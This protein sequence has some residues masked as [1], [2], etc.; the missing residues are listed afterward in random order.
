LAVANYESANGHLPP[1]FVRGPDGTPWHSWRVLILPYIEADDIFKQYRFDE[2]WDGPHNR[3]LADRMPRIFAFHNHWQPGQTTTNYL[4]VVGP[5]TA[6]PT[7]GKR[8][9]ADLMGRG[10]S[11]V[12]LIAENR[13]LGV[14]W[15]EPCD[16]DAAAMS[17]E[18]N[19]PDGLSSWYKMPAVAMADGS[20]RRMSSECGPDALRAAVRIRGPRV[21]LDQAG[22]P[23]IP[24]GRAR[25]GA[26]P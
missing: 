22:C 13:G 3:R 18:F 15:M 24:D 11:N 8:T 21:E 5:D 23:V 2:P 20:V 9:F 7:A 17:Y 12:V 1:P 26:D 25:P 6:W 14:H 10:I 16:L 4:A 19:A